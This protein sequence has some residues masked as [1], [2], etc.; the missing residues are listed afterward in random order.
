MINCSALM[1]CVGCEKCRLWGKLQVLG[2]GTA[3]KI[4]FSV[5]NDNLI[6]QQVCLFHIYWLCSRIMLIFRCHIDDSSLLFFQLQLHRN[7]VIALANLLNRL[8]E[9]VKFVHEKGPY[10]ERIMEKKISSYTSKSSS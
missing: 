2:L 3:L 7:E 8:S 5:D 9:S 10:A 6:N 4:L 1:D